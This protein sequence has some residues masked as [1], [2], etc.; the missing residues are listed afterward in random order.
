MEQFDKKHP[1]MKLKNLMF[2]SEGKLDKA[3]N[4]LDQFWMNVG[5]FMVPCCTLQLCMISYLSAIMEVVLFFAHCKSN[6]AIMARCIS[7]S[8]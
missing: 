7:V 3:L 1:I 6:A 8:T 4:I 5:F 2:T